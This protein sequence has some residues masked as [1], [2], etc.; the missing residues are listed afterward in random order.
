[1]DPYDLVFEQ[2]KEFLYE[3]LDQ[4][5]TPVKL[6]CETNTF[7]FQLR[8]Q[9]IKSFYKDGG[10]W[11][12]VIFRTKFSSAMNCRI[13]R[14]KNPQVIVDKS[15]HPEKVTVWHALWTDVVID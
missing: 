3:F 11:W 1:M 2:H 7:P 15:L 9:I 12:T 4:N 6:S 14:S 8:I 5:S 13:W 10:G